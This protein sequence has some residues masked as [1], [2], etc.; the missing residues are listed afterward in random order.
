[1]R[2]RCPG[3]SATTH[4]PAH[5]RRSD[6]PPA[7]IRAR[8]GAGGRAAWHWVTSWPKLAYPTISARAAREATGRV[9]P[10]IRRWSVTAAGGISL[11]WR[12]GM[13][14]GRVTLRGWGIQLVCL[15]GPA[16]RS[17]GRI[18][19][20]TGVWCW[21]RIEPLGRDAAGWLVH[22]APGL[23]GRV[24]LRCAGW[25]PG[26]LARLTRHT[27][28][29][30]GWLLVRLV[31]YCL[32]Y[33]EY[34]GIVGEARDLDRPRRARAAIVAWR[35]AATR[36]SIA[37]L[38]VGLGGWLGL[39]WLDHTHG[40]LAVTVVL[41]G[42][43]AGLAGVGRAVRPL[44]EPTPGGNAGEPGPDEP[45]PIADAHTRAEAAECVARAVRAEEIELRGTEDPHRA[46]WGWQVAV[47]LRR[48]TPAG[49]VAKLGELETTLDLPAGGLLAAPDRTRRARVMLRL[50]E[51]DPFAGLPP[52]IHRPPLST[53]IRDDQIVARR[54]DGTDL[55]LCLLGVHTMV[56]GV[57]GA[58]KSQT[59]RILGDAVSACADALVWDLDPA[60]NGLDVLGDGITRR[61][62][63]PAGIQDALT[64]ALA[65]AEVRP[66][67]LASL[68]M[69]DAW[70]PNPTHPALV[71]V[72][73]EYPRL[74]EK[75]KARAVDLLR[76]GR[77]SRVTVLLASSEATSDALGA[78]IA[79]TAACKILL[80]CRHTDVRLAL[81]PNM[82]AEGWRPDRLHPAAGDSPQDAGKA[83][84]WA[85]GARD[86]VISKFRLL[87]PD[88]AHENGAHRAAAGLPRL[89][90][91]SW[92]A[93]R[94]RRAH[95][96]PD[97]SGPSGDRQVGTDVL[98]AFGT[99]RKLWT[100]VLLT[101][102]AALNEVYS[103]WGPDD[104]A[105]ALRPFR[106]TPIQ[107]WKDGRNRNGYDRDTVARALNTN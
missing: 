20:R 76:V 97:P 23:A 102:L 94:A 83:Y 55:G 72:I 38:I 73:D 42:L 14:A 8:L 49:L 54:M 71:V 9:L 21:Y 103:N 48:G 100:E 67:M 105:E 31:R 36:R 93:A 86:P 10:T 46:P 85:A 101:R 2:S 78:A 41:A 104:L 24:L 89:D 62:R 40:T 74:S 53:S 25:L 96:H 92:T 84:V 69:G 44:P 13:V 16:A 45:F 91:D 79:E 50:A 35:Q 15:G 90:T 27:A 34:A 37:T 68:G 63:D 43:V 56:I 75:A 4:D 80:A 59:L 19:R 12:R 30:L 82:I 39:W 11:V 5:P 98:T 51:H 6:T 60:G 57:S 29:G 18:A 52:A 81:G 106:I 95:H 65:L 66:R 99:D 70:Q 87:D 3:N 32:A 17:T 107:I 1:M 22:T 88:R 7:G 61:E 28:V 26:A 47:I 33:P 58:G 77:K 64:D